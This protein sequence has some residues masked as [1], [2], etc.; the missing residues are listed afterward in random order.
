MKKY[1]IILTAAL[2]LGF[3]ACDDFAEPNPPLQSN[4][5]EASMTVDGLTVSAGEDVATG[6]LNLDQVNA[7]A[8]NVALLSIDAAENV[9]AGYDLKFVMQLSDSED[10]ASYREVETEVVDNIVYVTPDNWENAH[11]LTF[12]KSPKTRTTYVRTEAYVTNGVTDVRLGGLDT[13]FGVATLD[14]TPYDLGIVIEEA[15]YLVGTISDWSVASA[16]K[17]DREGDDVY[18]N[19]VFTIHVNIS[20]DQAESGWWWKIVPQSTYETGNW[21]DAKNGSYGVEVDGDDALSGL[22]QARTDTE[23]CG[24]GC[25]KQAGQYL[26]T[27][28][29][30]NCSYEFVS[31][32]EYLSTPGGSNGWAPASAMRLTTTDYVNYSG[33][34][35]LDG[36]YKFC[37]GD[38]WDNG[39]YGIGDAEGTLAYKGG[40]LSAETGLYWCAVNIEDLTYTLTKIETIGVVGT[41]VGSWDVDVDLTPSED[42][43]TWTGEIEMAAGEYKFRANDGWDVNLGGDINALV[44]GGA[45][46]MIEEAGTYSFELLLDATPYVVFVD[47]L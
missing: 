13:Y 21:V 9:P 12:G 6:A 4:E 29:M 30:E 10:F 47:K 8:L 3:V 32:W 39:D 20:A 31:A 19:P 2:A 33:F 38:S 43:L 16:V 25:V 34:A 37:L 7:D 24:A 15:Y 11:V 46:I 17:F 36:E 5:P 41:A 14:V 45:N 35:Y 22:L 1:S 23:D 44:P 40:N 28:D 26:L 27:I 42:M 18:A